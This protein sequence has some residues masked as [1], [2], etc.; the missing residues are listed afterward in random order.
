MLRDARL[1]RLLDAMIFGHG[2]GALAYLDVLNGS[3]W[4]ANHGFIA[5]AARAGLLHACVTLN[6][7]L[8]IEA[9]TRK[10]GRCVTECPLI[11]REFECGDGPELL[12]VVKLHG[13]FAPTSQASQPYEFL[14]AAISQAGTQPARANRKRLDELTEHSPTLLVAGYSDDDW[15]IFPMLQHIAPRFGRVVWL[16][17]AGTAEMAEEKLG[18]AR[19]GIPSKHGDGFERRVV[20]W[21]KRRCP[22]SLVVVCRA[23]S[24]LREVSTRCGLTWHDRAGVPGHTQTADMRMF[25]ID[26]NLFEERSV[27]S[28]LALAAFVQHTGEFSRRLLEQLQRHPLVRSSV[29]LAWRVEHL[30][31]HTE[32]TAGELR[33]ATHHMRCAIELKRSTGD[34]VGLAADWVWL[35]Y[36]H[37]CLAKRPGRRDRGP[38]QDARPPLVP[39]RMLR[40]AIIRWVLE[41]P[42]EVAMGLYFLARGLSSASGSKRERRT[43]RASALYYLGDLVHSWGN[44]SMLG[45]AQLVRKL[46]WCFGIPLA[47]YWL[48]GRVDP[49]W[50]DSGYYWMRRLEAGLLFRWG[51]PRGARPAVLERLGE[52]RDMHGLIQEY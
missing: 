26:R 40:D 15:D 34:R 31:A 51:L 6:F 13:S 2:P 17:Y 39:G 29:D 35:G 23:S 47:L 52:I 48:A 45:G 22:H 1:E 38:G 25:V 30:L 42:F 36:E 9:A 49:E 11:G 3:E 18:R 4:N 46:R 5:E 50:M 10:F 20:P 8:L 32:H 24:F 27:R 43:R 28:M 21:L 33:R 16:E 41:I 14:S 12:R 44:L 19:A 7:D 37:L